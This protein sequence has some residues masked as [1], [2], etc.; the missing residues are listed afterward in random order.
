MLVKIVENKQWKKWAVVPAR[1]E[2]A[3]MIVMVGVVSTKAAAVK[4]A[5]RHGH[6]IVKE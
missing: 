6:T 1:V 4:Y 3:T 5:T 2:D